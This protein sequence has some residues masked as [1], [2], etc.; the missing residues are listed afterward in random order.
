[1][2]VYSSKKCVG[3]LAQTLRKLLVTYVSVKCGNT[4][5]FFSHLGSSQKQKKSKQKIKKLAEF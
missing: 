5:F 3:N 2:N 4:C 1:M